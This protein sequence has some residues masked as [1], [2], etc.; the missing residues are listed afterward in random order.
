MSEKSC[1][2]CE[3]VLS[4][5]DAAAAGKKRAHIYPSFAPSCSLLISLFRSVCS[6]SRSRVHTHTH[7]H[8]ALAAFFA[9]KPHSLY[10]RRRSAASGALFS[11]PISVSQE[12]LLWQIKPT[13][14]N[15]R[16]VYAL[17]THTRWP[18]LPPAKR[19]NANLSN[20]CNYAGSIS[21]CW[22]NA[23]CSHVSLEG[24]VKLEW[25][26]LQLLT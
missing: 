22:V 21:H 6:S 18:F 20:D 3:C 7:T 23:I 19:A 13:A 10:A 1:V 17:H 4:A 11:L 26:Y 2:L 24:S 5:E 15:C 12:M 14:I 9:G 25:I 16:R 8:T